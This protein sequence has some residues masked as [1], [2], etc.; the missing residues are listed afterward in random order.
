MERPQAAQSLTKHITCYGP[1][2]GR[3]AGHVITPRPRQ[4]FVTCAM[5]V[6]VGYV[7]VMA[8][9]R[10]VRPSPPKHHLIITRFCTLLVL[11]VQ[12]K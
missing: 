10:C 9:G 12:V 8:G 11:I 4:S 3:S 2:S 7:S 1:G 6:F 5:C